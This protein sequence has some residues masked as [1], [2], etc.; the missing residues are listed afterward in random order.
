MRQDN[1]DDLDKTG[2]TFKAA[3]VAGPFRDTGE[4][5]SAV[6]VKRQVMV[7]SDLSILPD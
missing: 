4:N 1:P 3:F 2:L 6:V 5:P 7:K